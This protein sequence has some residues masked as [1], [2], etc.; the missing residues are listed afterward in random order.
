MKEREEAWS[1]I[2][3]LALQNPRLQKLSSPDVVTTKFVLPSTKE[4]PVEHVTDLSKV[5]MLPLT[6]GL[7]YRSPPLACRGD[8]RHC[9]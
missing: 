7:L 2:E 6:S 9:N 5:S 3:K 4:E 8:Q 1:T